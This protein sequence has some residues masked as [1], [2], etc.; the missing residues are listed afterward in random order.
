MVI[1]LLRG[2]AG[3]AIVDSHDRQLLQGMYAILELID[4]EALWRHLQRVSS[5]QDR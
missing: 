5:A 1:D 2:R 4:G 3:A